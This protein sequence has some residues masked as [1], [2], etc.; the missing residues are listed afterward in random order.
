ML[1]GK[2]CHIFVG[3]EYGVTFIGWS[4]N[5]QG[6]HGLSN[7]LRAAIAE[8]VA[9]HAERR[10]QVTPVDA[11]SMVTP[12]AAEAEAG[13]LRR[14]LTVRSKAEL[15]K[16]LAEWLDSS[17]ASTVGDIGRYGGK[18]WVDLVVDGERVVLQ[19]DTKRTAISSFVAHASRRGAEQPWSV[20][21][22]ARGKINKV[23][24]TTEPAPGWYCYLATPW[25]EP[26]RF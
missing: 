1:D 13:F 20:I 3:Q 6:S 17:T 26:G 23:V 10:V 21:A 8:G 9:A 4:L 19:A 7:T 16:V 5:L 2:S 25:R 24:Y 18:A 12:P 11:D 22:N 14:G 15:V